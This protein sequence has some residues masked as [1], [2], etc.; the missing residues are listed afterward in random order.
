MSYINPY[1][2]FVGAFIPNW[3]MERAEISSS[4]KLC[5]ARL[6]QFAGED[7]KCYPKQSTIAESLGVTE[8]TARTLV[9]ELVSFGLISIER[10]G[11]QSPN[12]YRF[13]DHEWIAMDSEDDTNSSG[14]NRK[15]SAGVHRKNSSSPEENQSEDNINTPPIRIPE[16][17]ASLP[18]VVESKIDPQVE[19]LYKTYPR[20]VGKVTAIKAIQKALRSHTYDFLIEATAAYAQAVAQWDE[21]K[22]GYVPH[23]ATWFNQQR[24]ND[25][26]VEWTRNQKKPHLDPIALEREARSLETQIENHMANPEYVRYRENPAKEL[27]EELNQLRRRLAEVRKLRNQS[28]SAFQP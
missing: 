17:N 24:F 4:A 28:Y 3:L 25:D 22:L 19:S 7:G 11:L 1:R 12:E 16:E 13:L 2:A 8:R 14:P 21:T 27:V 6:C 5:Y 9:N 10:A 18:A 20:K 26:R 15:F 23:P